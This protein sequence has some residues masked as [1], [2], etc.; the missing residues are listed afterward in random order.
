M[1]NGT[2][3]PQFNFSIH[4]DMSYSIYFKREMKVDD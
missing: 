2:M 1:V 4:L 3:A